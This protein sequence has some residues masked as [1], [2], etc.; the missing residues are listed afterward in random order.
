VLEAARGG[1]PFSVRELG[2]KVIDMAGMVLLPVVMLG[3]IVHA[4][5]RAWVKR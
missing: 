2:V 5:V 4:G 3:V 1:R